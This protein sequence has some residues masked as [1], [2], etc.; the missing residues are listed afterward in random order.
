MSENATRSESP[1]RSIMLNE[2]SQDSI[3][4][5]RVLSPVKKL[6]M[7]AMLVVTKRPPSSP[8]KGIRLKNPSESEIIAIMRSKME[9]GM[10]RST[11]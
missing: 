6:I 7:W 9:K 10:W 8:G 11:A 2:L 3:R 5:N 1:S 4:I